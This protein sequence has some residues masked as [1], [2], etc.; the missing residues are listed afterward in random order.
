[1][2][3]YISS[4]NK[5]SNEPFVSKKT[6]IIIT[7]IIIIII[8]I[9]L[10]IYF[11]VIKKNSDSGSGGGNTPTSG[12][13]S[14]TTTIPYV[15]PVPGKLITTI[16]YV[17]PVPGKPVLVPEWGGWATTTRDTEPS[18][19]P[20]T[21][22]FP[23]T[24]FDLNKIIANGNGQKIGSIQVN[25]SGELIDVIGTMGTAIPWP[26]F[27]SI[28]GWQSR[29]EMLSTIIDSCAG[30]NN[31]PCC[32]IAQPISKF[33]DEISPT[34]STNSNFDM[35]NNLCKT[36]CKDINDSSITATYNNGTKY[37]AYLLVPFQGCGGDCNTTFPDC[38]NSTPDIQ[39]L[40]QN[41]NLYTN[42][43]TS[44]GGP[45]P[46]PSGAENIKKLS[47]NKWK[48]STAIE[49]SY[50]NSNDATFA[51]SDK[52]QYGRDITDAAK[53]SQNPGRINYCSGKNM[54]F[55]VQTVSGYPF[56]CNL[57]CN[58]DPENSINLTSSDGKSRGGD[59]TNGT[60]V[61]YMLVPGNIFG[62]F[63]ILANGGNMPKLP[64]PTNVC[65]GGGGGGNNHCGLSWND[66]NLCKNPTCSS[67]DDCKSI[68]N[69]NCYTPS[70]TW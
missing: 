39:T 49:N 68:P 22:M 19:W 38:F 12:P 3:K 48:M 61:R 66:P 34:S 51:I 56:W 55:D 60:I 14:T 52:S 31:V 67:I 9:A 54:H 23:G 47:D 36:N 37:P 41:F 35:I 4:R 13:G 7:I 50:Y 44:S 69:S 25:K 6:L 65:P 20:G 21:E 63:D 45:I 17:P 59:I 29:I 24:S 42:C 1:M 26:I 15:P 8:A 28:F 58:G 27:A 11:L 53:T 32:I 18:L 5:K 10:P 43:K 16:P 46:V 64:L 57:S 2:G 30:R 62:N 40:I 33:P 70:V